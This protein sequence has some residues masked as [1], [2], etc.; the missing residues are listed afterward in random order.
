MPMGFH[1]RSLPPLLTTAV[2]VWALMQPL[3]AEE[4]HKSAAA[5]RLTQTS[6]NRELTAGTEQW[7]GDDAGPQVSN[8]LFTPGIMLQ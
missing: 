8:Y 1:I 3:R 5:T 7:A 6:T 2:L 4:A